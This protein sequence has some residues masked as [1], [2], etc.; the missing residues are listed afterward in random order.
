MASIKNEFRSSQKWFNDI[1]PAAKDLAE[2]T[3]DELLASDP[4]LLRVMYR[5]W[6]GPVDMD[7]RKTVAEIVHKH[8]VHM[9]DWLQYMMKKNGRKNPCD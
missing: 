1:A 3:V 5:E 4:V 7:D 6:M 8:H 2:T 9:W